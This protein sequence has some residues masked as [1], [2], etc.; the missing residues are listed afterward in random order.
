MKSIEDGAKTTIYCATDP[1][2]ASQTGRCYDDCKERKPNP[3]AEDEKLAAELWSRSET[4]TAAAATKTRTD[5]QV[6][7]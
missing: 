1:S 3:V 6:A 7:G 5:Y 4:W 2:L